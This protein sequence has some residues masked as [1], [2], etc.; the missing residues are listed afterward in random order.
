VGWVGKDYDSD[1]Q[2]GEKEIHEIRL[3]SEVQPSSYVSH[4][5]LLLLMLLLL[6]LLLLAVFELLLH[7]VGVSRVSC[8]D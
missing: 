5:L 1:D 7:M 2:Q 6:L 3:A 4:L 8:S